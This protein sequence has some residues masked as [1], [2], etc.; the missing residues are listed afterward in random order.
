MP[1]PDD[2]LETVRHA[3]PSL[4][5]DLKVANGTLIDPN[6]YSDST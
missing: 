4:S 3:N 1:G 2:W 5:S 6:V